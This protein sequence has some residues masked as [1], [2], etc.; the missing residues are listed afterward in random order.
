MCVFGHFFSS[1]CN[2]SW[3]WM[4]VCWLYMGVDGCVSVCMC[5][6]RW[7]CVRQILFPNF[8]ML[9]GISLIRFV[10]QAVCVHLC[11]CVSVDLSVCVCVSVFGVLYCTKTFVVVLMVT[12]AVV[13][14]V[15]FWWW[16]VSIIC[17]PFWSRQFACVERL[18]IDSILLNNFLIHIFRF[19]DVYCRRVFC[20]CLWCIRLVGW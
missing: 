5:E 9:I 15:V 8:H 7:W 2:G 3:T 6:R 12:V 11:V 16:Y 14:V 1:N 18:C 19:R 4:Y 17:S 13:V 20:V 10:C